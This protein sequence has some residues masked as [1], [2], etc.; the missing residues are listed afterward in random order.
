MDLPPTVRVSA[1]T[2]QLIDRREALQ[3]AALEKPS[4][5]ESFAVQLNSHPLDS[6]CEVAPGGRRGVVRFVGCPGG[7]PRPLVA[8]ELDSPQGDD[9]QTSGRWLDGV[10][11]FKPSAE[12]APVVWKSPQDV[13]CGDFPELDPFADLEI[14]D[15]ELP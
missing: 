1:A 2:L 9:I 6:R 3:E 11:Y 14:S 5:A 7:V 4:Q 10:E 15:G 12:R 8:V 13:V